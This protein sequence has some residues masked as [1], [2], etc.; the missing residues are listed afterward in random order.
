[1]DSPPTALP[2][3]IARSNI[4]LMNCMHYLPYV[5]TNTFRCLVLIA[6]VI[7]LPACDSGEPTAGGDEKWLDAPDALDNFLIAVNKKTV[8]SDSSGTSCESIIG[9]IRESLIINPGATGV[10]M[11]VSACSDAGMK[12]GK[13]IRCKL[14]RLQVKCQ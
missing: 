8:V 4:M 5:N 11:I 10:Q 7:A 13:A 14:G 9:D 1:M 6:A 2:V 3:T 12:F